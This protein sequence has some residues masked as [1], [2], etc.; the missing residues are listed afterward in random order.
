MSKRNWVDFLVFIIEFAIYTFT[1]WLFVSIILTFL[2]LFLN[3]VSGGNLIDIILKFRIPFLIL[4][5]LT[6][7]FVLWHGIRKNKEE[8]IDWISKL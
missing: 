7:L 8:I 3:F 5:I 2:L 1:I 4:V 6:F